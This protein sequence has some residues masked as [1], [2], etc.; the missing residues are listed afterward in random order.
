MG[1]VFSKIGENG[2]ANL[3]EAIDKWI[4]ITLERLG[5]EGTLYRRALV[6][7][8]VVIGVSILVGAIVLSKAI[9]KATWDMLNMSAKEG[10]LN[11][12]ALYDVT[13][14][15]LTFQLILIGVLVIISSRDPARCPA[16][17]RRNRDK[18]SDKHRRQANNTPT[19]KYQM[20]GAYPVGRKVTS[21]R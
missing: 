19:R 17:T 14:Y 7:A 21:K 10:V 8:A 1:S 6:G 12:K 15:V 5:I 13:F 16:K 2:L 20:P 18:V 11:R 4:P 3:R 9:A